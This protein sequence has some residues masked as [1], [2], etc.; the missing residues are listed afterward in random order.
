MEKQVSVCFVSP[1]LNQ[2]V[3]DR[4]SS[5]SQASY[6]FVLGPSQD[7]TIVLTDSE[8]IADQLPDRNVRPILMSSLSDD[9]IVRR[10]PIRLGIKG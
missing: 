8:E 7:S 3:F 9:E 4:L 6:H 1:E 5:I 10:A 2:R